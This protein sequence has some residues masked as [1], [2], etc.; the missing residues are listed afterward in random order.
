MSISNE[1]KFKKLWKD[2]SVKV[3]ETSLYYSLYYSSHHAKSYKMLGKETANHNVEVIEKYN[4]FFS[5]LEE[6]A[7][8]AA[9]LSTT[10]FFD[11]KRGLEKINYLLDE[12]AKFKIDRKENFDTLC[13][14]HKDTIK[15]L[16][17]V[18]NEHFAHRSIEKRKLVIPSHDKVFDLLN[19]IMKLLNS[20]GGEFGESYRWS[21]CKPGWSE[22]VKRD[23]QRVIDN[24]YRGEAARL[25]EI[26]VKYNKKIYDDFS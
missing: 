9:I 6:S 20:I 21:E 16:E 5:S 2:F 13:K 19:D 17:K 10:M 23:F 24:L 7:C 18:R 26:N 4:Y 15:R 11:K 25:A 14:N 1:E 22:D 3:Y 8:Y 12:A